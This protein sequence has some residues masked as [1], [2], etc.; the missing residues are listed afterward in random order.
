ME[1][2]KEANVLEKVLTNRSLKQ[3]CVFLCTYMGIGQMCVYFTVLYTILYKHITHTRKENPRGAKPLGMVD[4]IRPHNKCHSLFSQPRF[5]YQLE[6]SWVEYKVTRVV[7]EGDC[8]RKNIFFNSSYLT[9]L[10]LAFRQVLGSIK[11]GYLR[12]VWC[13]TKYRLL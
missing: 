13:T 1:K 12:R 7:E 9:S 11:K 2:R 6:H 10:D 3:K 5:I 4:I 8:R